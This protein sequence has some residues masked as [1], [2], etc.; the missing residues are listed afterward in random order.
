MSKHSQNISCFLLAGG[1][2]KRFGHNKAL[3]KIGGERL[4]DIIIKKLSE[5]FPE[6]FLITTPRNSYQDIQIKKLFDIIPNKGSLGGVYTGLVESKTSHSF[7][8]ACDMPFINVEL[9]KFMLGKK[10]DYDLLIPKTEKGLQPL[11]AIYSK[12]CIPHIKKLIDEDNFKILDFFD[13]VKVEYISEKICRKFDPEGN[14]FLNI[15]TLEDLKIAE[16][17]NL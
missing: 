1:Q 11:H 17:M 12:A 15:N 8:F 5:V 7:F 3:I 16:K 9:I 14:I 4:I 2:S 10:P 13:M 6:V